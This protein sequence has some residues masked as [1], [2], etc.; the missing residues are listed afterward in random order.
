MPNH[1]ATATRR[2]TQVREERTH[3][4]LAVAAAAAD[5]ATAARWRDQA[6]IENYDLACALAGKYA[7]RGVEIEDLQQVALMALVLAVRR[8]EPGSRSF[9]A[10]AIPTITGEIKRYFRDYTH[11]VRPPRTLYEAY[12]QVLRSTEELQR[13]HGVT[14]T[15]QDVAAAVDMTTE[16]VV[17][18]RAVPSRSTTTSWDAIRPGSDS[19]YYREPVAVDALEGLADRMSLRQA[20][21]ALPEQDQEL[22]R[23]RFEQELTQAQIGPLLG[24]SQMQISRR[25]ARVLGQLRSRLGDDFLHLAA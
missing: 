24:V 7:R 23:L 6:V 2:R 19:G 18:A 22:L 4:A 5:P 25:L 12:Q 21:A 3:H 14:P 8:F 9:T 17:Q 13:A 15:D 16:Q 1:A 20:M 11:V 10:Y